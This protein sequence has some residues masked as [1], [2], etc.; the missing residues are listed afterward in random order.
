MPSNVTA[1]DDGFTDCAVLEYY[2]NSTA[3]SWGTSVM[4]TSFPGNASRVRLKL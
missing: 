1:V 3:A 4:E 2:I